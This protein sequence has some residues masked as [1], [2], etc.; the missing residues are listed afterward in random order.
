MENYHRS[1]KEYWLAR[2]GDTENQHKNPKGLYTMLTPLVKAEEI[3]WKWTLD[4]G[5]AVLLEKKKGLFQIQ[6]IKL[7]S[8]R[9]QRAKHTP[10]KRSCSERRRRTGQQIALQSGNTG[11]GGGGHD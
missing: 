4:P 8:L 7:K 3:V 1:E 5:Q 9:M 10:V 6:R 11:R 2:N